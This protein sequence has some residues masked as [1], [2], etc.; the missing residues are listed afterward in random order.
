M[1]NCRILS[2]KKTLGL[3]ETWEKDNVDGAHPEELQASG[4]STLDAIVRCMS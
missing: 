2:I 3:G 1:P 4:V